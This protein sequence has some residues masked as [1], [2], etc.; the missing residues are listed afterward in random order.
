MVF[1]LYKPYFLSLY[2]NPTSKPSPCRKLCAFL[3]SQK[4]N[5]VWFISLLNYGDTEI[6]LINHLLLVIPMSCLWHY[7][8]LCP[9]KPHK[10]A[11]T[12]MSTMIALLS[13]QSSNH[14]STWLG[15]KPRPHANK[16]S[17]KMKCI[18]TSHRQL[19]KR[20]ELENVPKTMLYLHS[21]NNQSCELLKF[22]QQ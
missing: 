17:L 13:L 4:T 14:F 2:N 16:S 12:H 22:H 19:N 7:T 3:L 20:S 5:S 11:H 8:N 18:A 15:R 10:H 6:V 1:I 21:L 9:H